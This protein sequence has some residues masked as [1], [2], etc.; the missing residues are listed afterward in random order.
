MPERRNLYQLIGANKAKTLFFIIG[1]SLLLGLVGYGLGWYFQWGTGAYALFGLF[2]IGY[3]LILYYNSDKLA[4]AV[5]GAKPADPAEF[6]Q[7]HNIVEEV[8]IAAGTPKPKVHVIDTDAPNAFATGRNPSHA[9]IAVTRGLLAVMNREELQG[10]V[11][12]ELSHVRNYDILL[13]TVVAIIGG[14]LVLFRDVFLRWGLFGSGRRRRDDRGGGQLG[15]ILL[16]VAVAF[17]VISPLLVALIRAAISRQREYLADASAALMVRN[18][19][20]LSSALRKLGA[21]EGKLR[22]ASAATAHM[23][24]ANPLG[25]DHGTS[26]NLFASH[27]PIAD[28]IQRLEQLVIPEE[29]GKT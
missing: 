14:L 29:S 17:A 9:S 21:Y 27:P 13:M 12:H 26:V 8:A 10:V 19:Y 1:F 4:L 15:L 2:I 11:A 6:Q 16:V 20:G 28:R 25:K 23:F 18:P 24:I 5:N 3:N 22:S 7:L